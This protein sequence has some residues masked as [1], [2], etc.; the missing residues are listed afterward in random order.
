VSGT[1][2]KTKYQRISEQLQ[3]QIKNG[4]LTP[5]DQLPGEMALAKEYGVSRLTVRQALG[6]LAAENIVTSI[7]GKG[8]FVSQRPA[9]TSPSLKTV[10]LL[11]FSVHENHDSDPFF[12]KLVLE[13][14]R[15]LTGQGWSLTLSL[16]NKYETFG[17]FVARNGIPPTFRNGLIL[18]S[19]T[20]GNDDLEILC[21]EKI[22]Y[23]ILPSYEMELPAPVV[24][25]DDSVGIRRCMEFLLKFG[26]RKIGLLSC[27][28]DFHA[29]NYLL[30]GYRDSLEQ[31]ELPFLPELVMETTPWSEEEGRNSMAKLLERNVSFT[32][33]LIYGDQAT[34]GAVRLLLEKGIRI[35]EDLSV[36]ACDRYAWLDMLFSFKLAGIEQNVRHIAATAL[37]F[38][39]QQRDTGKTI[40]KKILVEP[41]LFPGN[42]CQYKF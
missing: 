13:L 40:A 3:A 12:Q 29:F 32:A 25:T 6:N 9:V 33:L 34:V 15:A 38:L 4:I 37:D 8:S 18:A 27:Q 22:P 1:A 10:H 24:G 21:R 39:K 42:S 30:D 28:P 36:M 19:A 20:A 26:H 16:L 35:P 17:E 14:S 31:A 23:V 11:S 41:E 2:K 5:G 7:Q